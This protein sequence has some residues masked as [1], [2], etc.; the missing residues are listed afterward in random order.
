MPHGV[1]QVQTHRSLPL[2]RAYNETS[3]LG[4]DPNRYYFLNNAP[5]DFSQPHIN[6]LAPDIYIS[7]TRITDHAV[8][9]RLESTS[10]NK[11]TAVG[12]SLPTPPVGYIP[13]TLRSTG[14]GQYTVE[15]DLSQPVVIFFGPLQQVNLPYNLRE[16]QFYV[17]LQFNGIFELGSIHDS[18]ERWTQTVDNIEKEVINAVPPNHG[19]TILQ[20]PLRL[21]QA[22]STFSFSV[23][24]HEGC[25][26]GVLFQVRL[27]GQTYFETFKDTFDWTDSSISLSQFA[28][29]P[30]LL[31]LVTDPGENTAC[32]WAYWADLLITATPNPDANLDGRIN[33]LD[34]ITVAG[35]LGQQPP[36]NPQ[37]DTNKDDVVNILDLVFVA[38]ASESKLPPRRPS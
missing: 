35:S 5:R 6:S 19:Q 33:V 23:G 29:Q 32:D 18:G 17:G 28:G 26:S 10:S 11:R 3:L 38:E 20:F 24:L 1:T 9:F 15:V 14:L 8:L 13:D 7:E 12:F 30:V 27:N 22:P 2:W 4:L 16:A 21:P 31:E 37:A 25:S 34:L 36:S